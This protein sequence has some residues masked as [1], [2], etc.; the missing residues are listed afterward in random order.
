M[1]EEEIGPDLLLRR[2]NGRHLVVAFST[3]VSATSGKFE[4]SNAMLDHK[5]HVLL[6]RDSGGDSYHSGFA[7]VTDSIEE[8]VEFLAYLRRRLD[9][10]RVTCLG[11]CTGGY[12][13]LLHGF[14]VG[15]DDVL[16]AN[17]RT[18]CDYDIAR[19]R[20]CGPRW[21]G[22]FDAVYEYYAKREEVPRYLDLRALFESRDSTVG[23]M[24]AYHSEN[25]KMDRNN[26]HAI[27]DF[28][29]IFPVP[30]KSKTHTELGARLRDRGVLEA[31]LRTE[32]ADLA[33]MHLAMEANA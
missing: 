10:E 5:G 28:P 21:P 6:A 26:A 12:A 25:L 13:A 23:P 3:V 16:T 1:L 22:Q 30:S 24:I 32:P 27:Q 17:A 9:V 19:K 7:G 11:I 4:F 29:Q 14:L 2:G 20:R 8:N 31:H 18:C 33:R 15:A